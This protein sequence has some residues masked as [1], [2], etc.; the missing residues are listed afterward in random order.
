ML[1]A[2]A[3]RRPVVTTPAGDAGD[4]VEE[5]VSGYVVPFDDV[6]AMAGRM[7]RLAESPELRTSFGAAGR[8]RVE[9]DHSYDGLADRLITVYEAIA[10]RQGRRDI[11]AALTGLRGHPEGQCPNETAGIREPIRRETAETGISKNCTA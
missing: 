10:E 7:V 2:M 5:G 9:K 3:A 11:L 1:E 6:E 8:R 4:V